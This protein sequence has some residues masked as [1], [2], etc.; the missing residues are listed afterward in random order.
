MTRRGTSWVAVRAAALAALLLG[1]GCT[2]VK[3]FAYRPAGAKAAEPRVAAKLAV[4]P[5]E[6]ATEVY[7][8]KGGYLEPET[9]WWNLARGGVPSVF[10]P[11]TAPLWAQAFARELGASGRFR[12]AR[13][14]VDESE[15]LDEDVVVTGALVR[16]DVA[17]AWMNPSQ[18]EFRATATRRKDGRRLWERSV[19]RAVPGKQ[20]YEA[21]GDFGL[22]CIVDHMHE[23]LRVVLAGMFEEAGADLA[24]TLAGRPAD[25]APVPGARAAPG[26]DASGEPVDET[27]RKILEGK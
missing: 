24:R 26:P 3:P 27:I 10:E 2:Y 5:F 12:G 8:K 11:V 7:E 13:Y 16:A 20:G 22:T 14:C 19:S 6:D 21:C 23:D 18:Y 25:G 4:L 17:G 1:A 15:V 9:L